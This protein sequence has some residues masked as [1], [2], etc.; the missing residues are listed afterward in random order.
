MRRTA[1]FLL[2]LL[3]ATPVLAVGRSEGVE[4]RSGSLLG[5]ALVA[6]LGR[7]DETVGV[8][9]F[10][11]DRTLAGVGWRH[12]SWKA[13]ALAG[14]FGYAY[15]GAGEGTARAVSFA[16]GH[17]T[18]MLGGKV[19]LELRQTILWE[20][21]SRLDVTQARVGWSLKF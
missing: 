14:T 16:A 21:E 4:L 18:A 1:A 15:T 11:E 19:S 13:T 10:A 7:S 8:G 6:D 5:F 3:L 12:D 9:R 17:E 2:S 20:G